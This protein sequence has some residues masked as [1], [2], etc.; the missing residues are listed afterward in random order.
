VLSAKETWVLSY[1]GKQHHAYTTKKER[2]K[3]RE[4]ERGREK[5]GG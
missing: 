5:I 2:R 4:R 1:N 3:R